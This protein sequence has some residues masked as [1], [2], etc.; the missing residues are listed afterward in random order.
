[1]EKLQLWLAG[2]Q[3]WMDGAFIA[4]C[5]LLWIVGWDR[6][7][8]PAAGKMNVDLIFISFGAVLAVIRFRKKKQ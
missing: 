1:M 7:E 2:H 3:L 6:I 4:F 8:V 5:I